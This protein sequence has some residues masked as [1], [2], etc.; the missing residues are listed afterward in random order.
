[1]AIFAW[2]EDMSVGNLTID[3]QHK[4]LV[5]LVNRLADAMQTGT[6]NAAMSGILNE[7]VSYTVKHFR[8]EEKI[9][10]ATAYPGAAA[11]KEK[12]KYLVSKVQELQKGLQ[13][14]QV[15]ISVVTLQ[16]LRDWLVE[17]IMKTDKTYSSYL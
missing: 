2:T 17:H 8:D 3:M 5:K 13:N 7:L 16:F 11:H 12:H 1:M 9:F 4:E 15:A 10:S 6:A 14:G